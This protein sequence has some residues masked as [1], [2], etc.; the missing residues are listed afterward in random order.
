MQHPPDRL[1]PK[2]AAFCIAS[3]SNSPSPNRILLKKCDREFSSIRD[4]IIA[5]LISLETS[6]NLTSQG[7]VNNG[8]SSSLA[9]LIASSDT[10]LM[11]GP[12]FTIK[13]EPFFSLIPLIKS[14]NSPSFSLIPT[15]VINM[16]SPPCSHLIPSNGFSKHSAT[17]IHSMLFSK[18]P[19]PPTRL[20]FLKESNLSI[21]FTEI[22][23]NF[24]LAPL[25]I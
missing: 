5:L 2:Y 11:Y 23:I 9:S 12:I 18:P 4:K 25:I 6:T 22:D 24:T 8:I 15:P 20:I 16:I 21:S 1:Y 7:N 17:Y 3:P 19:S 13:P 14:N 10:F